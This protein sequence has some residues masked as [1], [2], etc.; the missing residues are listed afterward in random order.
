M[1]KKFKII[2]LLFCVIFMTGCTA[3][4][5]ITIND[6]LTLTDSGYGDP[7]E[8]IYDDPSITLSDRVKNVV[9]V[10]I[11]TINELNYK[12]SVSDGGKLLKFYNSFKS[13]NEYKEKNGYVYQQWFRQLDIQDV[14]GIITLKASDFYPYT[15]Q[16]LDKIVIENLNINIKLPFKV[17]ETNADSIDRRN[18]TYT[19]SINR[20]TKEK[21]ILLRF[22]SKDNIKNKTNNIYII[23]LVVILTIVFGFIIRGFV[24]FK[25]INK[26]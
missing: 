18:Y 13:L 6:D 16:D 21:N 26:I 7:S 22:D 3:N 2:L 4:Y 14:N 5:D 17:L 11:D 25:N 19:W 9:R 20:N 1:I 10:N 23:I 24:K 12:Y 8:Y 15:E